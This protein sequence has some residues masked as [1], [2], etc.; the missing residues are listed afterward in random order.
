M[1]GAIMPF[2]KNKK[3]DLIDAVD[4]S[5]R[6]LIKKLLLGGT[7][8]YVAPVIASFSLNGPTV[9]AN[10]G[11]GVG[12]NMSHPLASNMVAESHPYGSNMRMANHPLGSN[13]RIA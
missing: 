9:F 4:E 13:Q 3:N 6:D 8:V 11:L 10:D 2:G 5:R 12:S 7:A 1:K